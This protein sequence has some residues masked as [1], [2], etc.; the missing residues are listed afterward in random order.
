M[1]INKNLEL[2]KP[3]LLIK[4]TNCMKYVRILNFIIGRHQ[5]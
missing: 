5:T 4:I 2:I 1:M 3:F